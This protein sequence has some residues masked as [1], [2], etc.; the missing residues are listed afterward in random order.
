MSKE[1]DGQSFHEWKMAE[2]S[3]DQLLEDILNTGLIL[4]AGK[5][6]GKTVTTMH[7]VRAF[8]KARPDVRI[9]IFD[10]C[11][12]WRWRYD[13]VPYFMMDTVV[14][15]LPSVNPIIV[16]VPFASSADT[17]M[18]VS[19][20]AL[21]DFG[22]KKGFKVATDDLPYWNLYVIEEIQNIFGTHALKGFE[23]EFWLKVVSEGRNFKQS[24]IGL[25]Q[26]LA[27]VS[28]EIVERAKGYLFGNLTGDNCLKKVNRIAGK[29]MKEAVRTLK[30]G[31]FLHYCAGSVHRFTF[32]MFKQQGKPYPYESKSDTS[33][34]QVED[35]SWLLKR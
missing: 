12:N 8:A 13:K 10:T 23:G 25:G 21:K 27:S 16:D 15:S 35:M 30:Q 9:N 32:P 11:L 33:R 4:V 14:D 18:A 28:T 6:H 3:I 20:V 2:A 31:Q 22:I 7:I 17:R 29:N 26:R 34:I 24:Y 19:S 5:N 1:D